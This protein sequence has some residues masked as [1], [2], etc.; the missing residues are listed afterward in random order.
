M[1]INFKSIIFLA[2]CGLLVWSFITIDRTAKEAVSELNTFPVI[3]EVK[4]TTTDHFHIIE[5]AQ[6]WVE[7]VENAGAEFG[8]DPLLIFAIA[9]AE[10]GLGKYYYNEYDREN[11]HNMWGLKGGN[12]NNRIA[13]E[14]SYIRCFND[15]VAGARTVAKTL[16]LYYL[17]EGRD[18]PEEICQKWIGAKHAE[19]HCPAWVANVNKI[20]AKN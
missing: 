11:C 20:L 10:S 16:K 5:V 6:E 13:K 18:T 12:T 14:G 15:E 8:V 17:D 1:K 7:P 9:N 2:I 19:K 3:E 4:A